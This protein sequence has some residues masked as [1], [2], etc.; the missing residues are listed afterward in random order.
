MTHTEIEL[1]IEETLLRV[2]ICNQPENLTALLDD[3]SEHF[4]HPEFC[5]IL[6]KRL[7]KALIT[8]SPRYQ[9]ITA[10]ESTHRIIKVL[11][12]LAKHHILDSTR[13]LHIQNMVRSLRNLPSTSPLALFW[14]NLGLTLSDTTQLQVTAATLFE[15]TMPLAI[16]GQ[17]LFEIHS[18]SFLN[19]ATVP[20]TN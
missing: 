20:S 16:W 9:E 15:V 11:A 3:F 17:L 14:S 13:T 12:R 8:L 4:S 2:F 7:A 10:Q 19:E 1:C 5:Q 6:C 18:H